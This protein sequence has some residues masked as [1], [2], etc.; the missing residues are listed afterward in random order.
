MTLFTRRSQLTTVRVHVASPAPSVSKIFGRSPGGVT[1]GALGLGVGPDERIPSF[2]P[3]IKG[4][5]YF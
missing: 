2:F 3:M 5:S 1:T 4:E